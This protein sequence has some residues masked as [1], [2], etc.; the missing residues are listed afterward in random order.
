MLK[1]IFSAFISALVLLS[2]V[3][4][5]NGVLSPGMQIIQKD[6]K[7]IKTC[8]YGEKIRFTKSDFSDVLGEEELKNI[9]VGSL[10]D[11]KY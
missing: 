3:I 9:T 6:I 8:S 11:A 5:V 1:K 7:V 10:P 2:A 4:S